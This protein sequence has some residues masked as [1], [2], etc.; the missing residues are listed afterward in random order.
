[1]LSQPIELSVFQTFN[2]QLM[3]T[4]KAV[5]RDDCIHEKNQTNDFSEEKVRTYGS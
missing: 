1:M 2:N 4:A 5:C 3:Q